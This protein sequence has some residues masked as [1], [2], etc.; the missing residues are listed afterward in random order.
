[1]TEQTLVLNEGQQEAADN[2]F[3]FLFDNEKEFSITG[4]AGTGKTT[5]MAYIMKNVIKEYQDAAA[6]M[7]TKGVDYE[8]HLTA[9]TNKAAEVLSVSTG[10]PV[11]TIHSFLGLRVRDNYKTGEQ[12]LMRTKN[13]KVYSNIILFVDEASMVDS[14]LYSHL[15]DA[16]DDTCKVIYLG[17]H[18]QMTPVNEDLS[19][20]YRNPKYSSPLIQPM[21]N[22]DQPAL[23]ALCS[24][25][26][27]TVETGLFKPIREVPGVI[28]YLTEDFAYNFM[29]HTFLHENPGC[30]ALA[31]S[32]VRVQ[33]YLSYIR[34]IRGYSEIFQVN[35]RVVNNSSF[36][37]GGDKIIPPES[38]HTISEVDPT[39]NVQTFKSQGEDFEIS[40][41]RVRLDNF[42]H[43]WFNVPT[44]FQRVKEV[45]NIFA[46]R[47]DWAP[48]FDVRDTFIDLRGSDAA[49]VYKAQGSSYDTVLLDLNDINRAHTLD[50]AARLLYVG[51]SRAR[52]KLYLWGEL[53]GRF[54]L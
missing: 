38:L 33:E 22:A 20:V 36:D 26:R 53:S 13:F 49:T 9:T 17:D 40:H 18:C 42:K 16:L 32:N 37:M 43:Q 3:H 27:Q 7:G 8:F 31:F 47:K 24:Q 25:L 54:F 46:R 30:R 50:Q 6:L 19:P 23:M 35:E 29:E 34:E 45:K 4:P 15:M 52:Q 28:E 48:M 14:K 12:T 21:R 44:D 11:S 5:L 41:Y 10:L 51:A 39:I 2:V 1:M